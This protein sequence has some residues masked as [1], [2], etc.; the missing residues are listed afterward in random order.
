MQRWIEAAALL[1]AACAKRDDGAGTA[2]SAAPEPV[3]SIAPAVTATAT[4]S[5]IATASASA[6]AAASAAPPRTKDAAAPAKLE[7]SAA[8]VE[9]KNF[10]LDVASPGCRAGEPCAMT[11]KL[12]AAADYHVNKEY[13]YKFVASPSAGIGFLGKG[14]ANVFSKAAGDFTED[15]AR[16]ATMTVRFTPASAGEAKVSGTYKMSICSDEQCQIEQ[17]PVSLSVKVL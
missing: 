11:I 6:S 17:Q 15:T 7:A 5:A 1:A 12:V 8:H 16:S 2:A 9:G 13:P 10:T 3:A 14:D 4:A